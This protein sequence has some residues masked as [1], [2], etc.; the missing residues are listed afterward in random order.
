MHPRGGHEARNRIRRTINGG[1]TSPTANIPGGREPAEVRLR[2]VELFGPAGRLEGV[3]NEAAP[4]AA[5]CALVCHPHPKGGGTLHNKVVYHAMKTLNAPAWGFGFPVLR[6]NFRG[7]GLSDGL[8]DGTEE[9]GDVLAAINF[10]EN[11]YD[12]PI[13]VA[14]FSFGAAKALEACTQTAAEVRAI[15][16]LGLPARAEGRTYVYPFLDRLSSPKLFLS[17][18][19]DQFSRPDDLQAIVDHA[20][21]PKELVLVPGADHFFTS[22]LDQMQKALADWLKEQVL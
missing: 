21:P 19:Q 11:E 16:A 18:D 12:L 20:C 17:G 3:V 15:V 14:G 8:H 1:M 9:V 5:F 4:D 10:L 6:F 7:V 22:R 13:V 2:T